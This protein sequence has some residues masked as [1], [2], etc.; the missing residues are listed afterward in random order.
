M[1]L[2]GT[3]IINNLEVGRYYAVTITGLTA[4]HT[5][6]LQYR[7]KGGW[8]TI[9]GTVGTGADDQDHIIL[10]TSSSIK[11]LVSAGTG[12]IEASFTKEQLR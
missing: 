8:H 1:T 3:D 12:D 5:T 9:N 11:V 10:I 4:G 6:A 7:D 2:T